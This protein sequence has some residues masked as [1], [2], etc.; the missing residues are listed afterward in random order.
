MMVRLFTKHF[1]VINLLFIAAAAW[2][3]AH[4]F[5]VVIQDRLSTFAMPGPTKGALAT[6]AE[7]PAPYDQYAIIPERN[8]FNPAEKGLKLL[9]LEEKGTGAIGA[10]G[11]SD[12]GKMVTSESY[13]LVGT[14]TGP[15]S[16]SWAILQENAD[17]KQKIFPLGGDVDGG[18]IVQI[19]RNRI[20]I[21]RQGKEEVLSIMEGEIGP[22]PAASP[23]TSTGQVVKKLSANRFVVNRED[24]NAAIGNVNQFM[25]QARIKPYF[26]MGRPGGFSVSEI[27]P[28]SLMEKLGLQ[29]GDVIKKVNGQSITKPEEVFQAYSQLQRDSNIEVEIERGNRSEVFRYEIR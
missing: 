8:I 28:G 21:R 25:T 19:F 26:L 12:S 18:K 23:A 15:G 11:A 29:N 6:P 16:R 9:P 22:R 20:L 17:R 24:V 1:W 7:K 27:K 5:A 2:L 3:V 4:L 13:R 14:V 10:R